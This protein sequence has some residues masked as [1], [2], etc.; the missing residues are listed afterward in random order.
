MRASKVLDKI[1]ISDAIIVLVHFSKNGDIKSF[2]ISVVVSAI[3]SY[4]INDKFIKSLIFLLFDT[5]FSNH[6]PSSTLFPRELKSWI[7]AIWVLTKTYKTI[8]RVIKSEKYKYRHQ[9]QDL[10][11]S[12]SNRLV[13]KIVFSIPIV[14]YKV[15]AEA[16]IASI[17]HPFFIC[18]LTSS[19]I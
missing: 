12:I 2:G 13:L 16:T 18:F 10:V 19:K 6:P 9:E 17:I 1:F 15:I 14:I 7:F 8:M 5:V 4:L 3:L 11:D